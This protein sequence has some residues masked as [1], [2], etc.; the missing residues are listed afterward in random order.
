MI[1]RLQ[2]YRALQTILQT[3]DPDIK[4][5]LLSLPITLN[6]THAETVRDQQITSEA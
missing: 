6:I 5:P 2:N 3:E 4:L 1:Y